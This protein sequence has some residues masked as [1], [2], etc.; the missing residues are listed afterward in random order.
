MALTFVLALSLAGVAA[1][2]SMPLATYAQQPPVRNAVYLK[3][4]R[5]NVTIDNQIAVTRIEQVFVNGGAGLAEGVYLFPLPAGAAVSDLTLTIDGQ[6]FKPQLLSAQEAQQIYTNIVRQRRDPVLLQYVGRDAIQAN[7][8]PIPAGAER[9]IEITYSNIVTGDSGL[10]RYVY[11]LKTDYVSGLPV[12]QTSVSVTVTSKDPI[13]T[14]YSPNPFVATTRLDARTIKAGFEGANY[15]ATDDFALYF[16]VANKDITANLLTYRAGANEDGFYMLMLAPPTT[17]D[18]TR[19]IPKDVF[20]VLDQSG[21]M[22]GEKWKQ[23]QAAAR[24]VLS[25]LNPQDRFN[26]I[27]FSTGYRIYA[28]GMQPVSEAQNAVR[29]IDGLEALG[30]T[31]INLALT[32]A[33]QLADPER[34]TT[35]LFMTDG[36][37]SEG[38][39]DPKSILANVDANRKPNLRLFAFGVGNDVDTFLLDSLSSRYGGTSVYVRP[40]ENIEEKVSTLYN[41]V[42]SPVLTNIK[43]D[44]GSIM[45]DDSYPA[46]PLPDLFAG[47]QL[48]VV[49]RYRAGG[50]TTITLTGSL[51]GTPQTLIYEGLSFANNA[52]GQAFIPRLWATRKIGALTNQIRLNG[53]RQE[54]VDGIVQLSIRYGIITPYTSFLIQENDM[55]PRDQQPRTPMPVL[56][57]ATAAAARVGSAGGQA[58]A[59]KNAVP[60]SSPSSGGVAVEAAS[61]ANAFQG[62]GSGVLAPTLTAAPTQVGANPVSAPVFEPEKGTGRANEPVKQVNDRAFVLRGGV[63]IDTRYTSDTMRLVPVTFLSDDYFKLLEAH[64]ELKDYLAIGDHLIVV[65][66]DVAYEI[67]PA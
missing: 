18:N 65:V 28:N 13:S 16:G 57:Q 11:P 55:I 56:M 6:I 49:G 52:G 39:T 5:V 7:I 38:V 34:Q 36:L 59:N 3:S 50:P 48:I 62:S 41:K 8:F 24:F 67:K 45:T 1:F 42:T 2:W 17:V 23:T 58:D 63:W 64:P 32:T 21:S 46:A 10:Y 30:G 12:L 35:L 37:P 40:L 9:K 15:L 54:L 61:T 14:F 26:V 53:A 43:L 29:W 22:Q 25:R 4:H 33:A 31:D 20:L 51:N 19:I 66:D 60:G 27:V 44:F 47:Q